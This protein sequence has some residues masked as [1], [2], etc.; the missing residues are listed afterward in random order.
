[1]Q[2]AGLYCTLLTVLRTMYVLV[3]W[4]VVW[5]GGG[6]DAVGVVSDAVVAAAAAAAVVVAARRYSLSDNVK[7][8][9]SPAHRRVGSSSIS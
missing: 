3:V 1:M 6:D 7:T 8:A 5:C 4:C 9:E 2:A